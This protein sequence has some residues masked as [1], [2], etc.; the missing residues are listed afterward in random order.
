MS[1]AFKIQ[2]DSETT[3]YVWEITE[4]LE[5]LM[6]LVVLRP[7]SEVRFSGMKSETHR[8]GFLSVRM[9]LLEAGYT[10]FDLFYDANGKPHL[11][12][13]SF[14]SIT[15]S[16]EYAGIIV[17]SKNVGIDIEMQRE[18]IVRIAGKFCNAGELEGLSGVLSERIR[19]LTVIWGAKEAMYK[20]CDS[21]SLS[22]KRDME[23]MPFGLLD[24]RGVSVVRSACGFQSDFS[25]WFVELNGFTVV[26][27]V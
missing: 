25:F 15:H 16:F 8:R 14:I 11:R 1:L 7:E 5:E 13:G 26:Y 24:E 21:R 3:V 18:K 23:V 4:A 10:D 22:F 17:S 20:M 2:H 12:D 6:A 9:L 19:E 27:A